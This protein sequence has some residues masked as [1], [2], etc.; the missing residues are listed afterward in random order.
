MIGKSCLCRFNATASRCESTECT[1]R[2]HLTS[3]SSL[4]CT[5]ADLTGFEDTHRFKL[6]DSQYLQFY[7]RVCLRCLLIKLKIIGCKRLT[8]LKSWSLK[9]S[10]TTAQDSEGKHDITVTVKIRNA[11]AWELKNVWDRRMKLMSHLVK[12]NRSLGIWAEFS[13]SASMALNGSLAAIYAG[14]NILLNPV[15][16]HLAVTWPNAGLWKFHLQTKSKFSWL[17]DWN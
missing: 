2:S 11:L 1:T 14:Q 16:P 10:K 17:I 13:P 4:A 12:R 5:H 3:G 6:D 9:S 7:W 8:W 15:Q